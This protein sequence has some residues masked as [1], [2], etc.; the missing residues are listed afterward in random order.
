MNGTVTRVN[1]AGDAQWLVGEMES[2]GLR[3][4]YRYACML[5]CLDVDVLVEERAREE[6]SASHLTLLKLVAAGIS[7]KSSVNWLMGGIEVRRLLEES[8]SSGLIDDGPAGLRLTAD[9]V[10]TLA[11]GFPVR[12]V[13][14]GLRYCAV[15]ERLLPRQA[16]TLEMQHADGGDVDARRA[17]VLGERA[18]IS[19]DNLRIEPRM[20]KAAFNVTDEAIAFTRILDYRPAYLRA[21]AVIAVKSGVQCAF[22][23]FGRVLVDYPLEQIRTLQ[24]PSSSG[25]VIEEAIPCI[26][27]E[28]RLGGLEV[29]EEVGRDA[30]GLPQFRIRTAPDAWLRRELTP[31]LTASQACG[32]PNV[33]ARAVT[34][35]DGHRPGKTR[36]SQRGDVLQGHA[37]TFVLAGRSEMSDAVEVFRD[38][39][40]RVAAYFATPSRQRSAETVREHLRVTLDP[41]TH[42]AAQALVHRFGTR[43]QAAWFDAEAAD[44]SSADEVAD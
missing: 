4:V 40:A 6:I 23:Q 27:E 36:T 12:Q 30:D 39:E 13:R 35:F 15:T 19:L 18:E 34:R 42:A 32:T 44:P 33:E 22:V 25:R 20:D 10:A 17:G 31:G 24:G 14:R 8:V 43:R 3:I 28:L 38:I 37:V 2:R 21:H 29:D 7:S 11:R 1:V 5:P 41:A 26:L 16:Y 9:G